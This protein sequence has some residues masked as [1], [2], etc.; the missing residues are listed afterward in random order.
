MVRA[1]PAHRPVRAFLFSTRRTLTVANP[2]VAAA[3]RCGDFLSLINE[4]LRTV[5]WE[6]AHAST[7]AGTRF[8]VLASR[9]RAVHVLQKQQ[10]VFRSNRDVLYVQLSA[11]A[12]GARV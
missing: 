7:K 3:G 8:L 6:T 10:E 5:G 1:W 4:N 12:V 11:S 2:H 9:R